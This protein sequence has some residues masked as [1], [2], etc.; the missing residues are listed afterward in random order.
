VCPPMTDP[1]LVQRLEG[2]AVLVA[3]GFAFDASGWSWWWFAALLLAADVSM[4]GYLAGPRLGAAV[5]NTG[6]MLVGP[7]ALLAWAW[8]GGPAA[9]L[10]IGAVWLAHI[11]IDRAFGY[12]LKHADG[13]HHTH[14]GLIGPRR[15]AT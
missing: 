7:A 11:G 6:H 1:T 10:A 8:A 14:L 4:A 13:F 9:A 12:G 5:Y 15:R 2:A 3:A